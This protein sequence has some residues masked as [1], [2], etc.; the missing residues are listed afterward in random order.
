MAT[1]FRNIV[2]K[3]I[4]TER[5]AVPIGIYATSTTVIGMNIANLTDHGKL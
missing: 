5:V 1:N 3:D 4:G 2:G